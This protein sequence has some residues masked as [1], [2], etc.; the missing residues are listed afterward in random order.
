M[1]VSKFQID[2]VDFPLLPYELF[3]AVEKSSLKF[4][5]Q[6]PSLILVISKHI[7]DKLSRYKMTV[8][9]LMHSRSFRGLT[10]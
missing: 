1:I 2:H 7:D 10:G 5:F 4:A 8:S 6:L 9:Y 3:P